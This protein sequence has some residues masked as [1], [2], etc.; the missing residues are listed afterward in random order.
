MTVRK[1]ISC[2]SLMLLISSMA[3]VPQASAHQTNYMTDARSGCRVVTPIAH[4]SALF[5]VVWSGVCRG[6]L[7]RGAGRL[8]V[9]YYGEIFMTLQGRFRDGKLVGRGIRWMRSG[10]EYRGPF[11]NNIPNGKG[12]IRFANRAIYRGM[13]VNGRMW[14]RGTLKLPGGH[15]RTVLYGK[16]VGR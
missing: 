11:R 8:T 1:W 7:A 3:L 2:T 15:Q 13:V 5:A 4:P 14:G 9:Y 12:A 16:L 10:E 6:G